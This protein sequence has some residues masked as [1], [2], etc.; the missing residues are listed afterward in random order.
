MLEPQLGMSFQEIVDWAKYAERQ[1]YGYFFRSDHLLPTQGERNRDSPEC[2]ISLGAVAATTKR[3]KF[4]PMVSPIGFRNPALL[5]QMACNL[6]A[7][8]HGRLLL[9]LGAGWYREEYVAKG[10]EFPEVQVRHRQLLEALQIIR[11]LTEGKPVSFSGDHYTAITI[12]YPRTKVS[13]I[14][15]GWSQFMRGLVDKFAD[16]WNLWN[17]TTSDF[18]EIKEHVKKSERKIEISRAGFFFIDETQKKLQ[19]KLE[20][21]SKLLGEL[22]L[23]A[24]VDG[25]RKNEILCG[26]VDDFKSQLN[27]FRK[28][29]VD[30]FYFDLLD[31]RDKEMVQLLTKILK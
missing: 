7:Y 27:Q 13:L 10:I 24:D 25:L 12:C 2:W 19:R 9:G 3:I 30:R 28:A 8:S 21:K 22:D 6:H 20:A 18:E 14:L 26:D 15:G 4:G 23:P 11:P 5:A 31:T 1:G 17:G 29:G 16:E